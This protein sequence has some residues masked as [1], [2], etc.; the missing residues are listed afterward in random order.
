[1]LKCDQ[2]FGLVRPN[3]RRPKGPPMTDEWWDDDGDAVDDGDLVQL[4]DGS[5]TLKPRSTAL[6]PVGVDPY[7]RAGEPRRLTPAQKRV[8]ATF[9]D[10]AARDREAASEVYEPGSVAG[11]AYAIQDTGRTQAPVGRPP[12][13]TDDPRQAARLLEGHYGRTIEQLRPLIG[14]GKR[15]DAQLAEAVAAIMDAHRATDKA[16]AAA[17][18]CHHSTVYRLAERGN[19]NKS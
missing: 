4:P 18:R 1:M 12:L 9:R 11:A 5:W 16:L 8:Q 19:A 2:L 15:A 6:S 10:T 3:P 17:L 14:R 7:R 13:G